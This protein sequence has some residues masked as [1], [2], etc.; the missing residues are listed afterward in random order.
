MLTRSTPDA[1]L[2]PVASPSSVHRT[3]PSRRAAWSRHVTLLILLLPLLTSTVGC[4][5]NPATGRSQVMLLSE[6]QERALGEQAKTE[7]LA[8]YGEYDDPELQDYVRALGHDLAA[9]SERPDLAWEFYLL[10]DP[11]VNAF[12]LPGGYVFITRGILSHLDNEAELAAILGHEVGHVVARHSANQISKQQLYSA[13]LL[14]GTLML[15]PEDRAWGALASAGLQVAF[16]QFSRDDEREADLL[17]LRYIEKVGYDP[18]PMPDVFET[19]DRVSAAAGAQGPP[20]W[21]RTHPTGADRVSRLN[22]AIGELGLNYDDRFIRAS[23]FHR[24][25]DG[26]VYGENPREGYFVGSAFYHPDM[27]FQ[28]NFPEGWKT[29]NTRAAV[30]AMSPRE[31]AFISLTLAQG[32]TL[33][34]AE[35]SFYDGSGVNYSGRVRT[36]ARGFQSLGSEFSASS[37]GNNLRGLVSFVDLGGGQI[38]QLLSASSSN[39]FRSNS[40]ELADTLGSVSELRDREYL[41]VTPKRIEVVRLPRAMTLEEFDQRYPSTV[42]IKTLAIVNQ[43]EAQDRLESGAFVKRIVGGELPYR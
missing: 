4:A 43:V 30:N 28:V 36:G 15:D 38:L 34:E 41:D 11:L 23:I 24:R 42:D 12:A 20:T 29:Q 39:A 2:S 17:G 18:R 21:L 9:K 31:D 16:L 26:M 7:M 32:D 40:G 19:L 37:N 1:A 6:E 35:R 25:L 14:I 8:L 22:G 27:R 3:A 13:G 5:T 33:Q 10:D